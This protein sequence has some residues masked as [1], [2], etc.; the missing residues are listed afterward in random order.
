MVHA[1]QTFRLFVSSTFNDLKAERNALQENVFPRLREMIA[2]YGHLQVIDLRWG[3]SEEASLDQQA[4]NIC[5]K[6]IER[7]Q[8]ITPRP[9]FLVLLGD[10]YGWLPPLSQI[11]D[12][13]FQMILKKTEDSDKAFLEDWY[14]LDKNAEPD[15]WRLKPRSSEKYKKYVD[16]QPVESRLYKIL[17]AAAKEL[18]TELDGRLLKYT[19]SATEQ[20]IVAGALSVEDA[21]DHVHC[22]FRSIGGIEDIPN[23]FS[24]Q[25]FQTLLRERIDEVFGGEELNKANQELITKLLEMPE[26]TNAGDFCELIKTAQDRAPK[27]TIEKEVVDYIHQTLVNVTAIEFINLNKNE[28][29]VEKEA[30]DAQDKLKKKLESHLPER[31]IHTYGAKWTGEGISTDHLELLCEDV[32]DSLLNVITKQVVWPKENVC[33]KKHEVKISPNEMLDEEGRAHHR[34]AEER[35]IVFVGR[36]KILKN[37]QSYLKDSQRQILAIVGEGGTGKSALAAKAIQETQANF[38]DAQVVYRFIGATP[39]STS[40][41]ILLE[42][43]CRE[44]SRRYDADETSVPIDYSDLVRELGIKMHLATDKKPLILFLDS[45]DQLFETNDARSLTWLPNVLPEHVSVVTSTRA[46]DT[47]ENLRAKQAKKEALEGLEQEDGEELLSQWLGNAKRKLQDSQRKY[48]LDKFKESKRNPLY[49][50]LAFEEARLWTS[51][52]DEPQEEFAVGVR[53]IIEKNMFDRLKKKENHGKELVS[54]ALGYLATSRNGLTEDELVDLLS[55]DLEVYRWFIKGTYHLPETLV[56]RAVEYC[57]KKNVDI[58]E[59]ESTRKERA[60]ISWLKSNRTPPDEVSKFLS[61][62]LPYKVGLGLPIVFWSR[63]YFDLSAFLNQRTVNGSSL[64]NFYHREL[65]DAV[66][67][68][69]LVDGQ[70][71]LYHTRLA[72][73][74]EGHS[75]DRR[76]TDELPWQYTQTGS[77]QKLYDLLADLPFFK[78]CYDADELEVR[79]YWAQVEGNSSLRVVEAYKPV[80]KDPEQYSKLVW[81]TA[82]LIKAMGHPEEALSLQEYLVEHYRNTG[83]RS[84]LHTAL[85]NQAIILYERGDLDEAMALDKESERICRELGNKD[86]LEISL[87]NQALI[88]HTRGDLDGAMA[89]Y[90]ESERI[91]RELGKWHGSLVNLNNQ[92]IIMQERG[93]LDGA[94]A[95]LLESERI[96]RELGNRDFL[97]GLLGNQALIL[98]TRGDLDGAMALYKESER[99]CRELGNKHGLLVNLNNQ[100]SILELRGDLDEAMALYKEQE[101]ICR[102][103]GNKD[104][105]QVSLGNQANML[106]I[107]GDSNGAM[108]LY[109]EQERICREL[110]NRDSLSR[111]LSNQATILGARG[112]LDGA[113]ALHKESERLCRELG[114]KDSLQGSLYNQAIIHFS[115]NDLDEAMALYKEQERICRELGNK[116]GL[117][118]SLIGQAVICSS[119]KQIKEALSLADEAYSLAADNGFVLI[120]KHIESKVI[121]ILKS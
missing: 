44:I 104:G 70:D 111:S 5:L 118:K 31:N 60:A 19:A 66:K 67:A 102:E 12:D 52:P 81:E 90:R 110:G 78:A 6:E 72:D 109:K 51:Q 58:N 82:M 121:P 9:N 69:F 18:E 23:N 64:L 26:G 116:V 34:F 45:L 112:D 59:E 83:D 79:A 95:F 113:M 8:N 40:G 50:K 99:I 21:E 94:M 77:W 100:A 92:A 80:L 4:M 106:R 2:E 65:G 53:G 74:F 84:K 75:L 63:L 28:W 114:N 10:R 35:L 61:E 91:C 36:E 13:E 25:A 88:L 96:C 22:F 32:Y 14:T 54:H 87:G 119:R 42:S 11:P 43:L 29:T 76:K 38:P 7:C 97:S 103:L 85:N 37:I 46:E 57:R 115:R 89:L 108:A 120:A 55:R 17:S 49:L 33:V 71:Q 62:T 41:R 47:F 24:S 27:E 20:E 3:V 15:E 117:V 16:W 101:R 68:K 93:D 1:K 39:G 73:Y 107:D 98:D 30:S 86:G 48:V 56:Q 105:L